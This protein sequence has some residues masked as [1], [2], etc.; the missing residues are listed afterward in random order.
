MGNDN[1]ALP[2]VI[3]CFIVGFVVFGAWV[4]FVTAGLQEW[5]GCENLNL[6]VK[7]KKQIS[8]P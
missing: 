2:L 3:S 5:E 8:K 4:S 1:Q 7:K 6:N